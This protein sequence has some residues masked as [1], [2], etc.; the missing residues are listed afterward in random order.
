M[1]QDIG[2][3]HGGGSR[4]MRPTGLWTTTPTDD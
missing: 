2:S 1:V 4:F 3:H